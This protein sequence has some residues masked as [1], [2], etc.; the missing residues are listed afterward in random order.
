MVSSGL[1]IFLVWIILIVASLPPSRPPW[2]HSWEGLKVLNLGSTDRVLKNSQ[3]LRSGV[4]KLGGSLSI[5]MEE[6]FVEE[7]DFQSPGLLMMLM[8]LLLPSPAIRSWDKNSIPTV[9]GGGSNAD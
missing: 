9:I 8:L 3:C 5:A 6:P 4:C 2:A 1:S 7:A